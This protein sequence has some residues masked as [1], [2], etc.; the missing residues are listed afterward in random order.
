MLHNVSKNICNEQF[1][2]TAHTIVVT[3]TQCVPDATENQRWV[4]IV[5]GRTF[6]SDLIT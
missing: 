6:E 4:D 2:K 5:D 1:P 3:S